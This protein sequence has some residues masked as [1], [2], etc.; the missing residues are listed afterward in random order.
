MT[1]NDLLDT[2]HVV[3]YVKSRDILEDGHLNCSAFQLRPGESGLS[4]NWIEYFKNLNKPEQIREVRRLIRL[5]MRP[6]GRLAELNVGRTRRRVDHALRFVHTPLPAEGGYP[7]DP[8][9]SEVQ[10]LPPGDSAD[11]ELIGDMIA[12]CVVSVHPAVADD[13]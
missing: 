3:R 10:G 9:H 2:D 5:G 12:E 1:G 4:V 13:G 11:A 6:S 7:A 8:S